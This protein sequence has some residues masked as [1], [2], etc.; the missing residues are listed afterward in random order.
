MTRIDFDRLIDR[1]GTYSLKYDARQRLFGRDDAIPLWVADMDFAAPPEVTQALMA[2]AQHPLYGYSEYPDALYEATQ[3]WFARRHSWHIAK[4]HILICPGVVPSLHAT[5]MALT[6]KHDKVIVQPPVYFPFF[7]AVTETQRSLVFNP[8]LRVG[9]TYQINFAE[10]AD[11]AA[12]GARMLLLCSP[13]N[14]GGRVW[15]ETELQQLLDIARQYQLLIVSDEIHA[16]LLFDGQRHIPLASLANDVA[17]VTA[18]SASK[19]FN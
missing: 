7:S 9:D 17:I 10:L 5:I 15:T 8:L 4:E 13:H 3:Q 11:Q 18:V 2:R 16:D 1:T 19:T 12:A 14:P 6:E